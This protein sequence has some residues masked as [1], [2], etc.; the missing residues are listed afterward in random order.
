MTSLLP[1]AVLPLPPEKL[2]VRC[3]TQQFDFTTTAD[4]ADMSDFIGQPRAMS[5]LEFAVGVR[6]PGYNLFVMGP[7]GA[8]KHAMVAQFLNERACHEP[9]PSDWVYV[10]NFKHTHKP[11]ALELPAGRG[12]ELSVAMQRLIDELR[13][14]IPATFDSDEYRTRGEH[15]DA[16][17]AE[18]HEKAFGA[19]SEEAATHQVSLLR[20]PNGFSLAP[21]KDG[22][23]IGAEDYEKLPAEEKK[24]IEAAIAMLQQKLERIIRNVMQWRKE[25]LERFRQLNREMTLLAV[26]HL[27]EELKARYADLPGV[28]AYLDAVREDVIDNADDFRQTGEPP[29]NVPAFMVAQPSFRRYQVNGVIAR[30][31][32]DGA[33]VVIEEHPTYQNLIGR[34]EHMSQFGTLTTDFTLIKPGALHRAAGGYL[35][36]DA[37]KVLTQWGAWEGLKRAL[38]TRSLRLESLAEMYSMVSTVS[39]EPEA[40]PLDLKVVLIGDRRLYYQ[41]YQSDPDFARLFKVCADFEDEF[42][43]SQANAHLFARMIATTLRREK[44]LPFDRGAVARTIEHSSRETGDARKLSSNIS[45]VIDL[46]SE[47][48]YWA[49]SRQQTLVTQADVQ[50]AID[51]QL[52]RTDRL[53][54]RVHEQI[55]RGTVMI[56]T[57]GARVGQINALSVYEFGNFAFAEPTRITATTRIG[58]GDV[59]DVQREVDMGGSIHS[60][61]VLILSAFMAAR[62]S[63]TRPHSMSASLV[64]EQTYGEIDGDSASLAELC[65]LLSSLADVPIR[66]SF[67]VTGSI[68]QLGQVQAIG[69]VNE[70]I[71]GFFDICRGRGLTGE[72]GVLIPASNVEHLMLRADV[73]EA[74]AAG[75]FRIFAVSTVDEAI[76]LLTGMAAGEAGVTVADTDNTINGRVAR[77]LHQFTTLRQSFA[78]GGAARR[79]RREKDKHG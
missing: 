23:V 18:R 14:A 19:L 11:L 46:L 40:I 10:N 57:S 43:R 38:S 22:E 15:I 17:F 78:A 25:R 36:L 58:D 49:R 6:R 37:Y 51:A 3:D 42:D 2:Y 21:V 41:L 44:L 8:G 1:S 62:Y 30:N 28:L 9:C 29:P 54:E 31:G 27:V 72:Q 52:H 66:Q 33:P 74:A 67:A 68:N 73:V 50:K 71:E 53:R 79:L 45:M 24:R 63:G 61:G 55:H 60:K 26:G 34:M 32:R 59:I 69:A 5:S 75:T 48:D 13:I 7:A 39:L 12:S 70:K 20:T 4:L 47:A 65:T 76:T 77:R 56:D 16:E 64:F 35:V